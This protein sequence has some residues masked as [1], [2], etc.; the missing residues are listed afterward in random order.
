MHTL[1]ENGIDAKDDILQKMMVAYGHLTAF[2]DVIPNMQKLGDI[3]N[4]KCVI[5]S[6]GNREMIKTSVSGSELSTID[7]LFEQSISVDHLRSFKPAP[8]VYR[9]LANC[10]NMSG[11]ESKIWLISSNPFDIVGARNVGMNAVWVDRKQSGW[12]DRLGSEPT[13]II[14]TLSELVDLVQSMQHP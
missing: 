6:N 2:D 14:N 7:Q 10:T 12:Q 3:A 5:F 11:K 4:V 13:K 8:E 1:L 9:Y